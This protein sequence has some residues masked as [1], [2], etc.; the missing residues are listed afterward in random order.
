[1]KRGA[2]LVVGLVVGLNCAK[3]PEEGDGLA[4]FR[5]ECRKD[6]CRLVDWQTC[7]C[8]EPD[9]WYRPPDPHDG[10]LPVVTTR[11]VFE[12]DGGRPPW[13]GSVFCLGECDAGPQYQ[14]YAFLRPDAGVP[15]L[16]VSK[17]LRD[18]R[19]EI[20]RLRNQLATCQRN[21]AN[22]KV[23][24]QMMVNADIARDLQDGGPCRCLPGEADG[25]GR[26]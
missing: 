8:L 22:D 17:V 23:L 9:P 26:R 6:G 1:M 25:C 16:D 7:S 10:G 21:E 3:P 13:P 20:H 5:A 15:R 2:M 11:P 12:W 14:Y 4:E 19:V 24:W 18:A